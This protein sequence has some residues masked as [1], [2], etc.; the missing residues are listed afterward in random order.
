MPFARTEVEGSH[1]NV[2]RTFG[3]II[4]MWR[5]GMSLQEINETLDFYAAGGR[6]MRCKK[7]KRPARGAKLTLWRQLVRFAW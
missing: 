6:N 2:L 5:D 7:T 1:V 3:W 4:A